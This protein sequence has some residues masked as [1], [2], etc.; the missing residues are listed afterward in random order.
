MIEPSTTPECC[1]SHQTSRKLLGGLLLFAVTLFFT[2]PALAAVASRAATSAASAAGGGITV[3]NGARDE[4]T[5]CGDITPAIPDGSIGDLLVA[6]V[7]ARR[8]AATV[9]MSGW[10]SLFSDNVVGTNYQ[11]FLFWRSATGTDPNTVNQA[12]TCNQFMATITRFGNVDTAQPLETQP[13]PSGNWAYTNAGDVDTG[14]QTISVANSMLVLAT[15]VADDRT[16][17]QNGSFTQIYDVGD[18]SGDDAGFSLN[19]RIDA[20][21]GSKGPFLNMDLSGNGNDPNHGVLFAVRPAAN[22]NGLTINKPAGTVAD[23]VMVAAIAVTPDT[24]GIT[25]PSGWTIVQDTEQPQD[26]GSHLITYYKTAT[27]S[28]TADYTWSFSAN[29]SGAV[30]GITTFSGVD[31]NSPIVSSASLA[32]DGD[33]AVNHTA[34]SITASTDDMLITVHEYQSSGTWTPPGGMTEAVDKYS[35]AATGANGVSLGMNYLLLSSTGATGTKVA[36]ASGNGD[37]GASQTLALRPFNLCFTDNFDGALSPNWSVGRQGGTYT[38]QITGSRLRLTDTSPAAATWATLGRIFPGAGNKVTAEFDHYAYGGT[39]ADGIAIILSNASIP[40]V[41]GAFGGS[42]GYAQKGQTPVSD[43]TVI[44]GCPGF[45]GGWLGIA[46]DEFGNYSTNTEG[47]VGGFATMVP[48]SVAIR[49]SGSGMSGYRYLIGT[50]SLTPIIDNNGAASPPHRYRI[51]VD[52][53]DSIH[54]WVSVERDTTGGGTSYTTV[55]GCAP[56]QTSGCTPLD[57]KDA[58]YSQDPVPAN[59]YFSFTGASGGATNIHEF[60]SLT[61]CTTQG[62][63]IPTLHHIR[64]EHD[65]QACTG[66][67]NPASITVKACANAACTSLYLDSVE[68]DLSNVATWS[69]DPVTFS[70]G[71]TTLSLSRTTAGTVTLGTTSTTPTASSATRCFNGATETCALTF[72]AC[73]FDVIETGAAAYTPIYT[74]L[75]G[76][77]FNLDVLSLSGVAQTVNKVEIVDASSGV[78]SGYVSLADSTTA[79]PSAFT[80]NQRKSFAFGYGNAVREARIRVTY[81]T[82]QYSCSSDNFAIRP[83]A[84]TV[85]STA[86]QTGSSGTPVFRA[87]LDTFSLT[88][89]ALSGYDGMPKINGNLLSSALPNLGLFGAVTFPNA[90]KATGVAMAAGFTYSEVGNFS[91]GQYAVYDDGFTAVDANKPLPECTSNFNNG[92]VVNGRY[93]CMFGST[94]AGPFGRFVPH[95]FT[96]VGAVANGCPAGSFTY[97][98]QPFTLFRTGDIAKAEVV[99][100][101]NAGDTATMNYAG[102]YAPGTVSFGAENADNGTDLSARLAFYSAGTYPALSGSWLGGVYTL[103]GNDTGAAFRRPT[104]TTPDTSWGPFDALD[105]GLTVA[106][107]DVSTS[108]KVS[109]ADMDPAAA[110]GPNLIHRKFSGSPLRMRYGRL[111]LANAFGPETEPVTMSARLEYYNGTAFALNAQDSCTNPGGIAVYQLDNTLEVN[112]T[113]GTILINGAAATNLTI[114]VTTAAAGLINLRFSPPGA[115]N[116]GNTQV[117]ALIAATLP[118]LLYEWDGAGND[119]NENPFARANFGIY[120]GNDRIINWRE[121]VR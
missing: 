52:H 112:Q 47:R 20:T 17:S 99:E 23:D 27:G 102:A 113:D 12:D 31:T 104:A 7:I 76:T 64:L 13:L 10:N 115:G 108:P 34:P 69:A 85:T 75:T 8:N 41:A 80:A 49:G 78:C 117:T 67:S 111:R 29:H 95:H 21:T 98:G 94:A 39:G 93:G 57:V 36:T 81:A 77:S 86:N 9:T 65:G 6:Q 110:G 60:D 92:P 89:T 25:P 116:I 22:A 96:V 40:P 61:V 66:S 74:K 106:D 83:Q 97:M 71:Q 100:A 68:V 15:F 107:S 63:V 30:G 70:G 53:T 38:P 18:N 90:S 59:W 120:R 118:W 121:V 62:Q 43:C 50:G 114:P 51:T 16:V 35:E 87:G 79:V 88:A 84:F 91:L 14:T 11:V 4:R 28:E 26:A 5:S 24:V 19:Y 82:N 56:G 33:T 45:A 55:L 54:A 103:T 44:G 105:L 119:F 73:T 3:T 109:D 2:Q 37:E 72:S 32:E 42:L 48:D 46:L 1:S 101:R 58:G